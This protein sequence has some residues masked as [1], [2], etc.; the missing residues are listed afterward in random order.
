MQRQH[1]VLLTV[2]GLALVCGDIWIGLRV[3]HD[4]VSWLKVALAILIQALSLLGLAVLLLLGPR[5]TEIRYAAP[6][7]AFRVAATPYLVFAMIVALSF[8][9]LYNGFACGDHPFP[10][11]IRGGP[12]CGNR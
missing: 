8:T 7:E 9:L 11:N 1:L 12:Q 5:R 4:S 6:F 2:I 10:P 3:A